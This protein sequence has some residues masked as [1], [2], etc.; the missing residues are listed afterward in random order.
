MRVA[1][2]G[3]VKVPVPRRFSVLGEV[4]SR[5]GPGLPHPERL[6]FG[7]HYDRVMQE[8]VQQAHGR[9]VLGQEPAPLVE[10]PVGAD[11][12]GPAL[13]GGGDEPEQELGACVVERGEARLV[14]DDE[15]VAEQVLDDAA[16]GVVGQAAVEGLDEIGGGEVACG[17]EDAATSNSSVVLST[18]NAA[19]SSG[20]GRWTHRGR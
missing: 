8:A 1:A 2:D 14:D 9:G 20:R 6:S 18:G 10:G 3:Q 15:V 13:V 17:I 4:S 12:E 19:A 11:A 5:L 7:D 16:G